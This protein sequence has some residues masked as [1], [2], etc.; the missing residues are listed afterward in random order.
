MNKAYQSLKKLLYTWVSTELDAEN[1]LRTSV[2]SVSANHIM[3]VKHASNSK[4]I[5]MPGN[6]DSVKARLFTHPLQWN[7]LSKM[8]VDSQLVWRSKTKLATKCC[9]VDIHAMVSKV[10]VNAY[11]AWTRNVLI[12]TKLL[13][14]VIILTHTVLSVIQ[15]VL[16][17]L[18]V[19]SLNVSTSSIWTAW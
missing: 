13:L 7:L 2:H 8:F 11:L 4:S 10:K 5:K 12:K 17:Q 1:A 15:M 3:L 6:V 16:V 18:H 19:Y 9:N 14:S